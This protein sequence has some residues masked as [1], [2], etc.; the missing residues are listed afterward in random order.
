MYE[1]RG[2]MHLL[3]QGV[4]FLSLFLIGLPINQFVN[5]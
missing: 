3:L 1:L 5:T 4:H 2:R